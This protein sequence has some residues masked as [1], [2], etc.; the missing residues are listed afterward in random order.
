MIVYD[1]GLWNKYICGLDTLS[2][3]F[4]FLLIHMDEKKLYLMTD[5]QLFAALRED[6]FQ[7][8]SRNGRVATSHCQ[9]L[10]QS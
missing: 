4:F 1:D 7:S 2:F 10:T 8:L 9:S 3:F 6:L 5:L